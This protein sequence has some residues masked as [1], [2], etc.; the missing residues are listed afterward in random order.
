MLL[1]EVNL[2][3]EREVAEAFAIWLA[4]HVREMLRLPGFEAAEWLRDEDE[5]EG[6]VRWSVHYRLRSRADLARYV[7]E[8]AERMRQEGLARFGGRFRASRR[9]LRLRERFTA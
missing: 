1:Y 8:D 6:E 9:V 2:S 5:G 3:V 7:A 4:E